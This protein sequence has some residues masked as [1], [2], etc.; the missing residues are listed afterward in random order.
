MG[1]SKPAVAGRAVPECPERGDSVFGLHALFACNL[2]AWAQPRD[3]ALLFD[4]V[5]VVYTASTVSEFLV[6]P[7]LWRH[8][9]FGDAGC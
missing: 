8:R 2:S 3:V 6:S 4:A 9:E 7:Y 1:A 5:R